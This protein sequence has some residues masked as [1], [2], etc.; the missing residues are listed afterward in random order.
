[1][2]PIHRAMAR[3][4]LPRIRAARLSAGAAALD[5]LHHSPASSYFLTSRTPCLSLAL[6]RGFPSMSLTPLAP[7]SSQLQLSLHS[8]LPIFSSTSFSCCHHVMEFIASTFQ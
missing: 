4:L 5:V 1:M 8:L 3:R 7:F 2:D 6:P